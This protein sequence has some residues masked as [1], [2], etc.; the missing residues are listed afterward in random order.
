MLEQWG[1]RYC[2]IGPYN[3]QTAAVEFEEQPTVRR[4]R[5]RRW[6]GCASRASPATSA[7]G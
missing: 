6:T 7:A 1:D 3:P 2:L 4:H 5:A